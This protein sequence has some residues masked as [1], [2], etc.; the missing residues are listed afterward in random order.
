VGSHY[1][2]NQRF[3]STLPDTFDNQVRLHACS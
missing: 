1:A 2:F 3:Y